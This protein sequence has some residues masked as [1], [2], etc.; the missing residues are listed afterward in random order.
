MEK[1]YK[2]YKRELLL[3]G[4]ILLMGLIFTLIEP[5]FFTPRNM[6]DIL[7]QTV[8]N[9][10]IALG[11]SFAIL[12]GGIDLSVGSTFALTIVVVG[13]LLV[14]GLNIYLAII[15]GVLFGFM[16]GM[17]NGFVVSKMQLQP[18]IATLGT[19]SIIRG[20]AYIITGGWPVLNI[21]QEFRNIFN[22]RLFNSIPLTVFYFI[23]FVI[24]TQII[25]KKTKLGTYIYG[26]GGNEEATY[27][28]G[29]NVDRVKIYAYGFSAALA[30][31]AGMVMLARLGSGE[32]ATGQGYETDAIAAAAI[33]GISMAGGKGDM[34][35]T[36]FGA[37]LI[38]VLKVGLVVVGVDAFWQY[39]AT[40]SIIVI[41]AY[42]D[43]FQAQFA[44]F[45]SRRKA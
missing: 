37:L 12:T 33:G 29:V 5:F 16:I 22:Y 27:L 44:K 6:I 8:V 25:L 38:S 9:G 35:G 43:I 32:P 4:T 14:M 19:M 36:F 15:V 26:V 42:S 34:I 21:P 13:S 41:A 11:I 23:F 31:I 20:I 17:F 1:I 28:S 7:D 18:F 30:A 45:R 3:I 10:F 40:G 24:L 39:V 2:Q